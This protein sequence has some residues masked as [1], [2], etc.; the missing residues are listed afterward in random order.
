[1]QLDRKLMAYTAAA[2]A[3]I[4][5]AGAESADA[6]II[7]SPGFT[8]AS[9]STNNINFDHS[10]AEEYQLGHRTGPFRVSLLKDSNALSTNAYAVTPANAQPAA[11]TLGT[12]IGPSSTYSTT[13][14]ADLAN[15]GTGAGNF[16]VDNVTGN[17]QYV[18]VKFQLAN[19]G[20]TY[21]G[22]IGVDITN[23]TDLTGQVTGY[24][25]EDSGGPIAAGAVPEP[26]SLALLALGAPFLLRRRRRA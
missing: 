21:Y 8:Y 18:G 1:M 5:A 22:W 16:T 6:A 11:L 12:I 4:A 20:P 10:G 25:Y 23:A 17:P 19:G 26:S 14:D 13:Y 24:A 9:G 2:G 7:S 15:Q 3:A